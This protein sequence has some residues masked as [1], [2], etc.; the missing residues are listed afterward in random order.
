MLLSGFKPVLVILDAPGHRRRPVFDW[1]HAFLPE[2]PLGIL[3]DVASCAGDNVRLLAEHI[4]RRVTIFHSCFIMSDLTPVAVNAVRAGR[5]KALYR[6]F[7]LWLVALGCENFQEQVPRIGL[8]VE[9]V[10]LRLV[11]FVVGA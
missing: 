8:E 7:I 4:S 3:I 1:R 9:G 6:G 5:V 10:V 11:D 2:Q